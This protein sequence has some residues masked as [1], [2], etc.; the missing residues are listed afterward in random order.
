LDLEKYDEAIQACSMLLDFQKTKSTGTSKP[1]EEGP[2]VEEKCVNANAIVGGTIDLY[3]KA[4][5]EDN[6]I[7]LDWAQ[8]SL[9]RLHELLAQISTVCTDP[10]V[11]EATAH[12]KAEVGD[13]QQVYK[14]LMKAYRSLQGVRGW[15]KDD[16]QVAKVCWNKESITKSKFLLSGVIKR[17]Q[18]SRIDSTKM[19]EEL[20]RLEELLEEVSKESN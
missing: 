1:G 7:A 9:E 17:V 16:R 14:N 5:N 12:V 10:W 6:A 3:R 11:H 20:H 18:Q 15:E 4:K 8:R 13:D 2:H 19:P